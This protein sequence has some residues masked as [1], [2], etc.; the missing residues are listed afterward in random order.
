MLCRSVSWRRNDESEAASLVA[1]ASAATPDVAGSEVERLFL[2][3]VAG[4]VTAV[5][6]DDLVFSG[7]F[8]AGLDLRLKREKKPLTRL[9][10]RRWKGTELAVAGEETPVG[11]DSAALPETASTGGRAM[12]LAVVSGT[13]KGTSLLV[14]ASMLLA[15]ASV[16]LVAACVSL[17][18]A[19]VSLA[20][21]TLER[22]RLLRALEELELTTVE[23]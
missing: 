15:I 11:S 7:V 13:D 1:G 19:S 10:L 23:T 22:L 4:R 2:A 21:S 8:S 17:V 18:A 12:A 9:D 5:V 20:S 6:S 16:L 3:S 14:T